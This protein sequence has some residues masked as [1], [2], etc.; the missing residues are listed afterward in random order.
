M[1]DNEW[2]LYRNRRFYIYCVLVSLLCFLIFL[3]TIVCR[4]ICLNA[5]RVL[6][7]KMF[8]RVIR[9]PIS[10]FDTNPVGRILNRF[11]NDIAAMDDSLPMT[12]L[13]FLVCLSQVLG[14]IILVVLLNPWSFI[15]AIIA[16]IGMLFVRYRFAPC[17]R[18]LKRLVGITRSLV[19]SQLTS[20][21]HGLKVIR[22]YHAENICSE[23]FY[24]HLDNNTRVY[25]LCAILNRWSAMRFDWVT[26][27]FIALVITLPIIVCIS[28]RQ[29]SAVEI[30]FTLTYK[31]A[32]YFRQSVE[33][34]IQ[35]TSV[36]RIL[37]YCSLEQEP[38]NQL[39][40]KYRSATNWPS[41][42]RIIFENVSM[43]HSKELHSPLVLH[44]ISLIIEPGEKIGI[45]GRTGAG[46]SSFIQTLFRMGT[47][48]N[49]HIIID[50]IDIATIDLDDVRRRISIIRQDPILFTGTMRSN[51]DPFGLYS[52]AEIWNALEQDLT[53]MMSND[54]HSLVNESGSNLNV[55]QKQLIC[56]ARALLKKSKILVIDETTANVDNITDELIQRAIRDKFKECTVLI[57]AHRLRTVIDSDRIIVLSNGKLVEFNSPQVLLSNDY[58]HISLLVEQTGAAEAKYL[59]TLANSIE[60]YT[61]RKKEICNLDDEWTLETN[62][63]DPLVPSLKSL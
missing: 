4:L 41:Q 50:N 34:E 28:Q 20:T 21:I 8:K 43:S 22:S 49:G 60:S 14:T 18:D 25:Y 42:G 56:L 39:P 55:G 19:Y 17:S 37:E 46:K 40:S 16:A 38:P 58:S 62:E 35:M 61:R 36:E 51:L 23:E 12:V 11:T 32:I 2:N 29:F 48:V 9:C 7:N 27:I 26:L 13:E 15:P 57:V 44:H 6:H 54:L 63:M 10:F 30:A 59:R 53:D 52:D 31:N 24:H 47:L 3:Q 5:G 45:V 33:V 1:N